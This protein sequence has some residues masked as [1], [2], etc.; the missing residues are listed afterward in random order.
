[1]EMNPRIMIHSTM[2]LRIFI[3]AVIVFCLISGVP[4][5]S[6]FSPAMNNV[7][8]H[9][10]RP[11][12]LRGNGWFAAMAAARCNAKPVTALLPW[13]RST[14]RKRRSSRPLTASV[15]QD[16]GPINGL[17]E[18]NQ[19]QQQQSRQRRPELWLD[20]R[21]T[22][23]RPQEALDFL[24]E[25]VLQEFM[26]DMNDDIDDAAEEAND[27]T[28]NEYCE[29]METLVDRVL[30]SSDIFDKVLDTDAKE[31]DLV[32]VV[33][34]KNDD[35][36]R[37]QQRQ[38]LMESRHE[39]QQSFSLGEI[40]QSSSPEASKSRR[41]NAVSS[42]LLNPME[43]LDIY[44]RGEIVF[45]DSNDEIADA[46]D[47]KNAALSSWLEQVEGLVQFLSSSLL[48][49]SSSFSVHPATHEDFNTSGLLMIGNQNYKIKNTND[50]SPSSRAAGIAI[51]CPNKQVFVRM[52]AMIM[53]L[54][55]S[56]SG[57]TGGASSTTTTDS[58]ILIPNAAAMD[59]P[60]LA[61]TDF[62]SS[63]TEAGTTA[64]ASVTPAAVA[65]STM[66]FVLPLDVNL[67][68][69]VLEVRRTTAAGE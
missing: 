24:N 23:I 50:S 44:S 61:L 37:Q 5:I 51:S 40:L 31:M 7:V 69:T 29:T 35:D 55:F 26:N 18:S 11:R 56:S 21:G 58:G 10:E 22:A 63:N 16:H 30:V 62:G 60:F 46:T 4:I 3:I 14:R 2:I 52:D 1:M 45:V 38:L 48:S 59:E 9:H 32:Y 68:K 19:Q 25:F 13:G 53:S 27:P 43:A 8:S 42:L 17:V 67:W 47:D 41:N 66:A 6:S 12:P 49:S 28:G 57:N 15:V 36:D 34:T 20:L 39:S 65:K 33:T 64:A 54:S